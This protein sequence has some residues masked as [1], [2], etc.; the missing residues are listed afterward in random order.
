MWTG[1]ATDGSMV[2]LWEA[3]TVRCT[4]LRRASGLAF[5]ITITCGSEVVSRRA[6]EHDE[7]AS[8]FAIAAMHRANEG[9]RLDP[10]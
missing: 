8:A 3:G 4:F 10:T 2:P 7:D 9:K 1:S 5:E 6:F